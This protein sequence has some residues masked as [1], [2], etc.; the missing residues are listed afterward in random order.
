[1]DPPHEFTRHG[2]IV[3]RVQPFKQCGPGQF[4]LAKV[5]R[6]R[7]QRPK[8]IVRQWH[9]DVLFNRRLGFLCVLDQ[10]IFRLRL[11]DFKALVDLQ[12]PVRRMAVANGPRRSV[13]RSRIWI[14]HQT[15]TLPAFQMGDGF[16]IDRHGVSPILLIAALISAMPIWIDRRSLVCPA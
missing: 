9:L 3:P 16:W 6:K 4:P 5:H 12:M 10:Q 1:M 8:L 11:R 14:C 13:L 15:A 7:Y 2:G